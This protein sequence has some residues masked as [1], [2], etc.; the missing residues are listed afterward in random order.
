M[1]HCLVL[2]KIHRCIGFAAT[3]QKRAR[4]EQHTA[5]NTTLPHTHTPHNTT[6][7]DAYAKSLHTHKS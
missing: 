1:Q 4:N 5:H 7:Q 6:Q 2:D 3:Q